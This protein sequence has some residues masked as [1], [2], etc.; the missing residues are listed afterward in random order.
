MCSSSYWV[1]S[2]WYSFVGLCAVGEFL[3]L[4][5]IVL[6]KFKYNLLARA[7]V[8][9]WILVATTSHQFLSGFW[10]LGFMSKILLPHL[11]DKEADLRNSFGALIALTHTSWTLYAVYHSRS[12]GYG[13][14][15]ARQDHD[16]HGAYNLRQRYNVISSRKKIKGDGFGGKGSLRRW[17]LSRGQKER[18]YNVRGRIPSQVCLILRLC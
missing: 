4:C 3:G 8:T 7:M 11:S 1:I 15:W 17:R 9:F 6:I 14:K 2:S 18:S 16:A 10:V 12:K 13:G 5:L